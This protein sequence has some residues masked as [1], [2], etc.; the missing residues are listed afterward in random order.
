MLF[1]QERSKERVCA[2]VQWGKKRWLQP[3]SFYFPLPARFVMVLLSVKIKMDFF[4]YILSNYDEKNE[5]R[6][7]WQSNNQSRCRIRFA[8]VVLFALS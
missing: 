7:R 4:C 1:H 8:K 2:Y 5:E 3:P 6:K